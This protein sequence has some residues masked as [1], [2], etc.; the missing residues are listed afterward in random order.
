MAR[1][2]KSGIKFR[3]WRVPDMGRHALA[4]AQVPQQ[5]ATDKTTSID[6]ETSF[7]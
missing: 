2:G 4:T 3:Y 6:L 1:I 7:A 5:A